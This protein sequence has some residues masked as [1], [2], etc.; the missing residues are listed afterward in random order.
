MG[1]LSP[2][3][4][5]E[6]ISMLAQKVNARAEEKWNSDVPTPGMQNTHPYLRRKRGYLLSEGF[7]TQDWNPECHNTLDVCDKALLD[8]SC[9][10]ALA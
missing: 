2:G 6:I 5:L 4:P 8:T 9:F 1:S 3:T 10:L 7:L